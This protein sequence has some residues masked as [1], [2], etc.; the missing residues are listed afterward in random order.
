MHSTSHWSFLVLHNLPFR[1]R[2]RLVLP[3]INLELETIGRVEDSFDNGVYDSSAV[4]GDAD[5][6]A[7]CMLTWG[8]FGLLRH[9]K[10]CTI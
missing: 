5:V 8:W 3:E 2:R 6:V 9:T 10:D 4:H 7:D 1:D